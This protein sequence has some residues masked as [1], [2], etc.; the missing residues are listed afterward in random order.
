M[1]IMQIRIQKLV[2]SLID[3]ISGNNTGRIEPV[4]EDDVKIRTAQVEKGVYIT[5]HSL[6][7]GGNVLKRCRFRRKLFTEK[8][9]E[10]WWCEN[11]GRILEHYNLQPSNHQSIPPRSED[12]ST[13]QTLSLNP[14][15]LEET[16]WIEQDEPGVYITVKALP[17][18]NRE[19]I[20]IRFSRAR[21][22]EVNASMWWEQNR[23]R[24]KEQYL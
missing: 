18:G 1:V 22:G 17:C 15:N 19:L 14:A 6:P 21:F 3:C 2:R 7:N 16:E 13:T 11:R 4:E 10:I 5:F 9:A 12:K 23:A 24:V 8:Q 20:R